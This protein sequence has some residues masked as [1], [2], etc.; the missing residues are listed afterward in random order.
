MT[1][2]NQHVT[3]DK[4]KWII[5]FI[6]LIL[7]VI[8]VV[9]MAVIMNRQFKTT[10]VL[11][12]DYEIGLFDSEG[13]E[14]DGKTAIRLRDFISVDGLEITVKEDV[15]VKYRVLFYDKDEDFLSATA[16]LDGDF[17]GEIPNKAVFCK[18]EITP[19]DADGEISVLEV[20]EYADLITVTVN[21]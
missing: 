9:S 7:I 20:L 13:A 3:A 11:S 1:E 19:E 10:E 17:D 12:T 8:A 14:K 15:K 16:L 5:T 4:A 21:R 2:L 18:V 6:A